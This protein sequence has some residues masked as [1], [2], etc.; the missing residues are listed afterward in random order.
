M[1]TQTMNTYPA[2]LHVRFGGRSFDVPAACLD[3]NP[4][5]E[6]RFI[7]RALAGHLEVPES[8]LRDYVI[9][10]HANGNMTLRPMAVFG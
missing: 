8:Q 4:A 2:V 7:K 9:D 1:A 5:T 10:R 3:V 6:D